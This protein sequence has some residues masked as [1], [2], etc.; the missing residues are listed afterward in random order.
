MGLSRLSSWWLAL[1]INL[2]RSRPGCPQDNGGHE[3][4]H[5]DI[6]R[7]IEPNRPVERQAVFDTWRKEFNEVRPHET[8]GM[9]TPA[10]VYRPSEKKWKGDIDQ[11]SYPG[12]ASRRVGS[13]GNIRIEGKQVFLTT[14]LTGWNV[15]L[16]PVA[17]GLWEVYFAKLLIGHIEPLSE[18]FIRNHYTPTNLP[19]AA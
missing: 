16:K 7:E 18:I 3:R 15:G 14:A 19:K 17:D 1:G 4:M 12:K 13:R 5:R 6:A 10:E 8:L 2:E 11:L 9:K